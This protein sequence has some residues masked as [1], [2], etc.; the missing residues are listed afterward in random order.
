MANNNSRNYGRFKKTLLAASIMA[1][2]SAAYAAEPAK[3]KELEDDDQIETVTVTG[4]RQAIMTAAELK[5]NS[6][7]IIDSIVADDAGKLPDNS[8][9]EVLQRIPGI[10]MSRWNGSGDQFVVEGSGIQV[11]GLSSASSMLNGREIFGANGGS[12]LSWGEVTPE[13]MAAVDVYKASRADIIEGGTGGAINLRTKM[14]FDYD[15]PAVNGSV[16][17][18]YADLVEDVDGSASILGTTRFDTSVGEMGFLV[19][20][21]YSKLQSKSGHLSV[22]PYYKKFYDANG[23]GVSDGESE[24]RYITGGF[25]WGDSNFQRERTGFYEAFQWAPTENLTIFQTA[26]VSNYKSD[27]NGTSVWISGDRTM[28]LRGSATTFDSNGVLVQADQMIYGSL[29]VGQGS[30]IGQGW[31]PEEQQVDCNAPYGEQAQSLNWGASPPNCTEQIRTA[32]SSRSFSESDNT[33]SDFSQGFTWNINERTRLRGALQYVYSTA[34]SSGMSAGLNVPVT[35]FSMDLRGDLPKFKIAN[36][37]TLLDPASYAWGQMSWRPTDNVGRMLAPNLDLDYDL[38]EGFFKTLSAGVRYASRYEEDLYDGTYWEPL[39]ND[40]NGWADGQQYLGDGPEA[41]GEYYGF[42]NFF[43]GS[44]PVPN[45]FYVPSEAL[46]SS[47]DYNYL[48]STYGYYVNKILPNGQQPTTPFESLHID[49]GKS[50]TEVDTSSFYILTS[51]GSETGLFGV[52][53]TGNLGVRYVHTDTQANGNFVF[54]FSRF[55]ISQADANADFMADNTGEIRPRAIT[56]QPDVQYLENETTDEQFLPSFN[57]NFKPLDNT[58]IRFAA[59]QT[60]ARPN[61]NDITVAGYGNTVLRENAN[62]YTEVTDEGEVNHEFLPIFDGLS[63]TTGNTLLKPTVSTNFDLSFEWYGNHGTA[64]HVSFFHKSLKDLIIYSDSAVPFDYGFMKENGESVS[65]TSILT[66]GQSVNADKDATI[67][68]FEVGARTYFDQLPG[69]WNGFGIDTNFTYIDSKNPSPKSY[70]MDGNR[71]E[72]LPV[73]GLSEYSY[74]IQLM[75]QKGGFYAGLGWNWRSRFL[76]STNANGTGQDNTTYNHYS[77]GNG[78]FEQIHYQLPLY[79]KAT[80]TLDFGMN[81]QFNDNLK[82]HLRA[83]NLLNEVSKSEMEILPGKFYAR[84]FYEADRRVDAG[85]NFSF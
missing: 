14:P 27:N 81:Y 13:L 61:F 59:S 29:G 78:S 42:E 7:T 10:T 44:I 84:N 85:I 66:R 71:F 38:G 50:V 45:S 72:N 37:D 8:I 79:G 80:G 6:D 60:M 70:D 19:H 75:Y 52:P 31:I 83:N 43:H 16:G 73:T 28:P 36:S 12:G 55:Y 54:N 69:L 24:Q 33:T 5:K 2:G 64:A 20:A 49:H 11:R 9:T 40:W 56:L 77:D 62:N 46:I 58:H 53:Y 32:G 74:N 23:N 34:K 67:Q 51:F 76:M 30:T 22:E 1:I 65:G 63:V 25:G 17:L 48:M 18:S 82:I 3:D 68:G 47:R 41:D 4:R 15:A 21:A 26:F 57:I 39:G 35:S